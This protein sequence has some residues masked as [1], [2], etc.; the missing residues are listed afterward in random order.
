MLRIYTL[1][2]T[3]DLV[4]A[5]KWEL[6]RNMAKAKIIYED[7]PVVFAKYRHPQSDDAVNYQSTIQIKDSGKQPI[8]M[9]LFLA[10]VS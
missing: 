6:E 7:R 1:L 9:K 8:T 2:P 10:K 5:F 3:E 4:Q